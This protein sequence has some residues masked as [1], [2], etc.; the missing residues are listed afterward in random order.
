MSV[1]ELPESIGNFLFYCILHIYIVFK[2]LIAAECIERRSRRPDNKLVPD[3]PEEELIQEIA[4]ISEIR[5]ALKHWLKLICNRVSIEYLVSSSK[6]IG[7][8]KNT[9]TKLTQ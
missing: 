6:T 1:W 9:P 7:Q 2:L 8:T 4:L 5:N 3:C